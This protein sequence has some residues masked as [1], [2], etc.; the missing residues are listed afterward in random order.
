MENVWHEIN[1]EGPFELP[2]EII[3][4]LAAQKANALNQDKAKA[5][6][7]LLDL[8]NV[9]PVQAVSDWVANHAEP[10]KCLAL[11]TMHQDVDHQPWL[12]AN[13]QPNA[14]LMLLADAEGVTPQAAKN[15]TKAELAAKWKAQDTAAIARAEKSAETRPASTPATTPTATPSPRVAPSGGAGAK[16]KTPAA[17]KPK[18]TQSQAEQTDP[19][20]ASAVGETSR[21]TSPDAGATPDIVPGARVVIVGGVHSGQAGTVIED[22]AA[23]TEE[24]PSRWRVQIDGDNDAETTEIDAKWLVLESRYVAWPFPGSKP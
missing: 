17:R 20:G 21:A 14:A 11:L 18:T 23:G 4:H 12:P 8:G 22:P 10:Q 2:A 7:K 3:R 13:S 9:A 1:Q 6:C 24:T 15:A 16:A 5:L 19:D